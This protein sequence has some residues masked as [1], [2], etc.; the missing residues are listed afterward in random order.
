MDG[1][2]A[3]SARPILFNSEMVRAILDG[4]KKVTR[5]IANINTEIT[6]NDGTANH[7]F[8]WDCFSGRPTPSGFVCR[9]CGFGVAPPHSRVPCGSSIFRPRYWPGDVLY[10]RETWQYAY[11]LD[12]NDYPLEETGRY[13]YAADDPQPFNDWVMP[14]GTHRDTMPWRP[15]IHM[16]KEAARIFLLVTDVRLQRLQTISADECLMEGVPPG[17][18]TVGERE[19]Y[20]KRAFAKLWNSTVY[21]AD[22]GAFGWAANPWVW[23]IKFER[24]EKPK[25]E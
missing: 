18:S 9:K 20:Y 25:E 11:D 7:A 16:P 14:D 2:T 12:G 19:E 10:V 3:Q 23:V 13:L 22:L 24:R 1:M 6:C 17:S 8:V 5:R 15:S 4:Q 21:S